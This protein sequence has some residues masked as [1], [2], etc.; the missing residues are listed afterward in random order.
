M[1]NE[2]TAGCCPARERTFNFARYARVWFAEGDLDTRRAIF[3]CLGSDFLLEDRKVRI[4]LQKPF[5]FIFDGL[6]EAENEIERL[7]PL[8]FG[9]KLMN[10]RDFRAKFPVLS[11]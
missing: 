3:A 1:K 4:T 11:G 10:M 2:K 7:E 9:Y 6:Q 8:T 5:K